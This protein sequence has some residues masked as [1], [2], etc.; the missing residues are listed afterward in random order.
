[1]KAEQ[2]IM[3]SVADASGSMTLGA[4]SQSLVAARPSRRWF[5]FQNQSAEPMWI[6]IGTTAAVADKPS[7]QVLA[8][9]GTFVLDKAVAREAMQIISATTGSKYTCLEGK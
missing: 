1:M 2:P 7:I 5:F 8:N 9:G 3:F 6:R 4:T